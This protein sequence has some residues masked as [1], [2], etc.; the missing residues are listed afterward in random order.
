MAQQ[1][2]RQLLAP[3]LI[4][5]G[6]ELPDDGAVKL[7]TFIELLVKWNAAYNLTAV[8]EPTEMVSKHLLD[9][10]TLAPYLHGKSIL[11]VGT[12]AGLPGIPL[13]IALPDR[14][15]TLLDSNGKKTRFLTHA[16]TA[17]GLK[18]VDVVQVRAED[19][20]P[21]EP[22]DTVTS[23]AFASLADFLELTV[24]LCTPGGYWLAMKGEPPDDELRA[25]PAGFRLVALHPV[26]VPGLDAQR[27][28]VKIER[29]V[30]RSGC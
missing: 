9:S 23:R 5:L 8:R 16:A 21:K 18:N 27:C 4:Q 30:L 11:D 2:W 24:H 20:R 22:F 19:Y 12:G 10:L 28:V 13:A 14:H 1:D 7:L 6:V 17:L 29:Q 25:L 15:F 26:H 3:G